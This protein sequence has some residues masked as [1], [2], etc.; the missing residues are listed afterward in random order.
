MRVEMR[1]KIRMIFV[2]KY[3]EFNP[4]KDYPSIR[5]YFSSEKHNG[6][7][8]IAYYLRHGKKIWYLSRYQKM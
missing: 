1:Q 8:K 4:G 6:Q 3:K 7:D 2:G 5:A